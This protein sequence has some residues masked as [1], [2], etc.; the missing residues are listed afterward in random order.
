L[1]KIKCRICGKEVN[2]E[3]GLLGHLKV[4]RRGQKFYRGSI[5][6]SEKDIDDWRWFVNYFR[7]KPGSSCHMIITWV[8]AFRA[9]VEA[10]AVPPNLR[11]PTVA[12]YQTFLGPPRSRYKELISE[13]FEPLK[14]SCPN[15]GSSDIVHAP[16]R[17][18][19][20]YNGRWYR[21]H[22][23]GYYFPRIR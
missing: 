18:Q 14:L 9:Y 7:D 22:K 21:C 13:G 1:G 19:F 11:P 15:C 20:S 12:V 6:I 3:K 16:L 4:H 2:G 17:T 23:C 10:K 5:R 8:K